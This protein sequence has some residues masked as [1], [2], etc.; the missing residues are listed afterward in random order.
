MKICLA[1][2]GIEKNCRETG[3][4]VVD[5]NFIIHMSELGHELSII[6]PTKREI[7]NCEVPKKVK[8]IRLG[9]INNKLLQVLSIFATALEFKKFLDRYPSGLI[10]CNSFFSSLLSL[11]LLLLLKKNAKF[12][13]QFH[14]KDS[15]KI[16]NFF[17]GRIVA[18]S[19]L[20][21]CPSNASKK[22][23]LSISKIN[24]E[25]VFVINHGIDSSFFKKNIKEQIIART[26]K[27]NEKLKLLFIGY[28]EPRKN[29]T[30]LIEIANLIIGQIDFEIHVIG[31][32]PEYIKMKQMLKGADVENKFYF[33]G[34]KSDDEKMAY[35]M[36]SDLFI[37]PSVHEGFG[38][39]LCEAMACGLP[40]IA[41]DV[42]A[43]SEVL[44]NKSSF[45]IELN[46]SSKMAEAITSLSNDRILLRK[47]SIESYKRSKKF[48]WNDKM[49]IISDIINKNCSDL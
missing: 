8:F 16:R 30:L 47:M 29:P 20:A 3:A 18:R 7:G 41:F 44:D 40:V 21:L 38:I 46:N 45:T 31:T 48:S 13:I 36:N 12:I 23:L 14:H 43:M 2:S 24:E 42:S 28:L 39:V 11:P 27:P 25:K 26:N 33:H 19:C 6:L 15:S 5:K 10:R 9:S 35:Y 4:S 34:E 49:P 37:F 22:E 32:G 17:V 1:I